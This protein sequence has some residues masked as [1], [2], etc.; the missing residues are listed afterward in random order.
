M[1]KTNK[2]KLFIGIFYI[3]LVSSFLIFIFSKFSYEEIA[4]YK[5][6]QLNRE[7]LVNV[8]TSNLFLLGLLFIFLTIF[9]V[10]LL[11]FGSPIGLLAG[12]VFGKF[13]GTFLAVLGCTLGATFLYIFAGYFFKESIKENFLNKFYNLEQK[14]KKNELGFFIFYRFIGAI[15]FSISN[16]IPLLFNVKIKNFFFGTFIG[17]FPS[18]FIIVNIGS[19]LEK[20]IRENE[21]APKIL[22]L[23]LSSEIYTPIISFFILIILAFLAKKF[24]YN[25]F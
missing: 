2:L 16:L 12:F 5:F 20:I 15:P 19:G 22:E 14:F 17:I 25:R 23:L 3:I 4:S 18:L 24:F 13:L 1:K 8:R 21:E 10:F 9:W 6:I 11:G 7:Y